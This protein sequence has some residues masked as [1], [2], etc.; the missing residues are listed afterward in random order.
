MKKNEIPLWQKFIGSTLFLG[1]IKGGG[2]WSSILAGILLFYFVDWASPSFFI[3]FFIILFLSIFLSFNLS[4][5]PSW[6]T[7]DEVTGIM[8][9]FG[10]HNKTLSTFVVGLILFRLFDIFKLPFIKKIEKTRF[11]IVLDDV[12]AGMLASIFLFVLHSVMP[13]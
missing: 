11:G 12:L 3:I 5:D 6:F 8:V 1:K 4:G 7:L 2:T 13:Q 9:T 10:F